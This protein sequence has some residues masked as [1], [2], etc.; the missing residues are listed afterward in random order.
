MKETIRKRKATV[1]LWKAYKIS[2]GLRG[3]FEEKPY[4]LAVVIEHIVSENLTKLLK[5]FTNG[6]TGYG[7]EW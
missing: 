2:T 6:S 5:E 1:K 4:F 3:M 7:V